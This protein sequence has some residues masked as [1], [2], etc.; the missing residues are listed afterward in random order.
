MLTLK[1]AFCQLQQIMPKCAFYGN[2]CM[3]GPTLILTDDSKSE[4]ESLKMTWPETTLLLCL[5]HYLQSWWTWLW[6]K[7]NG[8]E[9]KD[10]ILIMNIVRQMVYSHS[11]EELEEHYTKLTDPTETIPGKYQ[12][13]CDRTSTHWKSR[14]E[15]ALVYRKQLLTRGH[16]TNNVAEAG[17]RIVKDLVF[18]R[19]KAY[20]LVQMFGFITD[21]MELYYQNRLLQ[22]AHNRIS[23]PLIQKYGK[24]F[25]Q[26]VDI[27]VKQTHED[28][29]FCTYQTIQ[30]KEQSVTMQFKVN[31]LISAC[32]CDKGLSGAPCSHQVAVTLKQ[33]KNANTLLPVYKKEIK[34][35]FAK[36]ALGEAHKTTLGFYATIHE[37][38]LHADSMHPQESNE[39]DD[40]ADDFDI[41]RDKMVEP[42]FNS[43]KNTDNSKD[44]TTWDYI[45]CDVHNIMNDL[46]FRVE[47]GDIKF[48]KGVQKFISTYKQFL[49]GPAPTA[50]L[51]SA[52][53]YFG[54]NGKIINNN[55][56]NRNTSLFPFQIHY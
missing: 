56:I 46:I 8:I 44:T 27:T 3:K 14:C 13:V 34:R 26:A 36:V 42:K 35:L 31:T 15:W 32:N 43:D 47:Q 7:K 28:H 45:K 33:E 55:S 9:K 29:L 19:I 16:N 49:S 38:L 48:K 52:L 17:I 39:A 24:H 10:K 21:T 2:G 23:R 5:F 30:V 1:Q 18:E 6:E 51:S 11:E 22:I 20:N 54:K 25:K 41:P 12:N 53:H 40:D 4:R 50:T 37:K